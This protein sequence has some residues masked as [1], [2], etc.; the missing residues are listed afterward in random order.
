MQFTDTTAT[1]T[2]EP[3][4][5]YGETMS[6]GYRLTV[7]VAETTYYFWTQNLL[8]KTTG[9]GDVDSCIVP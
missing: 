6:R 9:W 8:A 2:R 3:Y 7:L 5:W 4:L 1:L